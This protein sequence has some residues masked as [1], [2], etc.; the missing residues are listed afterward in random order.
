VADGV[1]GHVVLDP[2]VVGAVH[3]TQRL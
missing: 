2:D 3:V 1:E